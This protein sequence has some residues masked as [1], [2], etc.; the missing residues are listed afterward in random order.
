MAETDPRELVPVTVELFVPDVEAS[1]SFYAEKLG[2]E[3]MRLERGMIDGQ[4]RATFAV[5]GLERAAFLI[6]HRT[7]EGAPAARPAGGA[8]HIRI[9]VDDVDALHRRAK[10]NGVAIIYDIADRAYGLRDFIVE[11]PD[12]FRVRF[13]SPL[14]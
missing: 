1:V 2:F 7:L 12:G 4:E 3:L 10:E 13:A 8:V 9:I 14:S 11:D 6:A 5:V